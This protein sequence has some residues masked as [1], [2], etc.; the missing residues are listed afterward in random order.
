MQPL[1]RIAHKEWQKHAA[2]L[3]AQPSN[4]RHLK[5]VPRDQR[6]A[7]ID[8]A[9]WQEEPK[10]MFCLGFVIGAILVAPA[11]IDLLGGMS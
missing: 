7:G 5:A 2:L 6:E 3:D 8:S 9:A 11:L 4:R 1:E 10:G